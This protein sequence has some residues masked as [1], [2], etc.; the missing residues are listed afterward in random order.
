MQSQFANRLIISVY[1]R[2]TGSFTWK[3]KIY[4]SKLKQILM[5]SYEEQPR[6]RSV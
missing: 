1:P 3:F 2:D 6:M 4:S 5:N